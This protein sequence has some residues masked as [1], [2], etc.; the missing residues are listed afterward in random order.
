MKIA[1]HYLLVI[2]TALSIMYSCSNSELPGKN[3]DSKE[4]LKVFLRDHYRNSKISGY[5][6]EDSTYNVKEVVLNSCKYI[7]DNQSK[8]IFSVTLTPDV[9]EP[10]SNYP[11]RYNNRVVI[12]SIDSDYTIRM[13]E[14]INIS[15]KID[16]L[17]TS[18]M[19][20]NGVQEIGIRHQSFSGGASE[21]SMTYTIIEEIDNNINEL[22]SLTSGYI[23]FDPQREYFVKFDRIWAMDEGEG[24]YDNHNW[25]VYMYKLTDDGLTKI[26]TSTTNKK[27]GWGR[28]ESI[29][30][31]AFANRNSLIVH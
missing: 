21:Y 29:Y 18:N 19:N 5:Y 30:R 22:G 23:L 16:T 26:I 1:P 28:Y 10:L 31:N 20:N 8:I 11:M 25:N 9:S 2:L 13:E 24:R 6:S 27:F 15:G 14:G 3:F 7:S 17:I 12:A 4:E